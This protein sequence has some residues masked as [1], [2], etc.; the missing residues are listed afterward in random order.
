MIAGSALFVSGCSAVDIESLA[1]DQNHYRLGIVRIKVPETRREISAYKIS[2][3][4]FLA[5]RGFFV[6]W[7]DS[8]RVL[9]PI[10]AGSAETPPQAACGIVI[11]VRSVTELNHAEQLTKGLKGGDV[12]IA[13]F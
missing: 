11:V 3:L 10:E 12:C 6:G 13:K 7:Q 4:G 9:V 8:E 2:S 5:S 1:R